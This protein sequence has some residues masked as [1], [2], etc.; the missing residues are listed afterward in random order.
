MLA[1]F[2]F[3]FFFIFSFINDGPKDDDEVAEGVVELD[4]LSET[5]RTKDLHEIVV[6]QV[7]AVSKE[8]GLSVSLVQRKTVTTTKRRSEKRKK[9]RKKRMTNSLVWVKRMSSRILECDPMMRIV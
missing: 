6:E 7:Q 5:K 3:L 1:F 9:K 2:S 4:V 8:L